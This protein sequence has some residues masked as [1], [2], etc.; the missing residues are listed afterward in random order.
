MSSCHISYITHYLV[1]L[2][3]FIYFQVFLQGVST[4]QLAMHSTVL[5]IVELS[6]CP[7]VCLCHTLVQWY[8]VLVC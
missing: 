2:I 1:D 7:S 8:C 6:V 4:A 3:K 5:A